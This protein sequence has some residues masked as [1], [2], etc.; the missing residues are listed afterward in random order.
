MSTPNTVKQLVK[1]ITSLSNSL[2]DAVPRGSKD[3]KI[4]FVMNTKEGDV[5]PHETFNRRFD[6]LFGEDCRDPG[7]RLHHIRQGK[8]GMGLVVSYLL[9]INWTNFPL[10]LVELKLERLIAELKHLQRVDVPRPVRTL[11]PTA[12]LKDA[13]NS[14]TP[15]LSFQRKA[16]LDF[17]SRQTD[18]NDPPTSST[19]AGDPN[20]PSSA[21]AVPTPPNKRNITSV[22]DHNSDG[23][24]GI[25]DQPARFKKKYA[26]TTTSQAKRIHAI[27]A[28]VDDVDMTDT[29]GDLRD[30]GIVFLNDDV[31]RLVF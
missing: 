26:T 11:N 29:E 23:D 17:H 9:K 16:V 14:E 27:S 8:L 10:D 15:Q 1:D 5:P 30:K 6:A 21:S 28:T 2:S 13:A 20:A 31:H 7:G 3:D 4:W 24:D 12:K 19:V 22:A 18:K 25:V